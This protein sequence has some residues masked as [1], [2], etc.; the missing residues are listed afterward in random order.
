MRVARNLEEETIQDA[1][2]FSRNV[3][4]QAGKGKAVLA[5][6]TGEDER[7]RELKSV[8]LYG[9]RS[10]ICVPL[11]SR[12]KIVGA[13]Y[14]DSRSDA[15]LFSPDDLRFLEAFADHAALALGERAGSG[16]NWSWR[17]SACSGRRRAASQFGNIVGRSRA[18]AGGLRPDR[19]V[20]DNSLPVLIQGESGTGKELVA[21]AIHSNGRAAQ[22]AV[23]GRKL[24]GDSRVAAGIG[25]VRPRARA[26]SPAP[27]AIAPGCSSRPTAA[28]C[29]WTRSATCPPAMQAR[30]LR[31]LQE[32]E[33]RRV[34][35]ERVDPG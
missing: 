5:V 2:E 13:V 17:T 14:L 24:R 9:I 25:T 30:L 4:L 10:V 7:L 1:S 33:L 21:R 34:G 26:R 35:G 22:A 18:D 19:K 6:D 29:C 32:G 31:V 15:S 28:R 23:R 8:S 3:V 16:A 27:T 11:R 12:G 20:A